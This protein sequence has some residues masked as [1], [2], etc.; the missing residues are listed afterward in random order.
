MTARRHTRR[1]PKGGI[2]MASFDTVW[3]GNT[4]LQWISAL[5]AVLILL[6]GFRLAKHAVIGRI[7]R[8]AEAQGG[9][10]LSSLAEILKRTSWLALAVLAAWT[11]AQLFLIAPPKIAWALDK[12]AA[13]VFLL[14]LGFWSNGLVRAVADKAAERNADNSTLVS[15]ARVVR[16]LAQVVIW[17]VVL[18]VFLHALHIDVTAIVA[19]LGLGGVA[20]GFAT[21]KIASD[22]FASFS[23]LLDKPIAVGDFIILGELMG[24]VERIGLRT[25]R[26]RSLAGEQLIFSNSDLV[27]SRIRNYRTIATRRNVLEFGVVYSTPLEKLKA[28]PG[29]IRSVAESVPKVRFDRAH[30]KTYGDFALL[31]EAVYFVD[32]AEY[33]VFMD[34]QQAVNIGIYAAFEEAGIEFAYPTQT[35][36]LAQPAGVDFPRA[37]R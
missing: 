16:V 14:Q 17:C 2:V 18:L 33:G 29:I 34:A 8:A 9:L 35:I 23:L 7:H 30:F 3:F 5:T 15:T 28:I 25:T 31:F 22:L 6:A 12:T 13:L 36:H 4:F 20:L 10:L 19:G 37:S 27:E 21:Q 24:T 1:A 26:V 32:D 11:A